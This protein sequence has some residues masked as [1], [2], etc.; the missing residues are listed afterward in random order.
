M[1]AWACAEQ[2]EVKNSENKPTRICVRMDD[3][4]F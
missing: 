4:P 1:G 3:A 2:I